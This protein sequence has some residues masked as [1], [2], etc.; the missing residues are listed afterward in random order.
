MALHAD[1]G[2]FFHGFQHDPGQTEQVDLGQQL[3]VNRS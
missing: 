1:R 2:A 3:A